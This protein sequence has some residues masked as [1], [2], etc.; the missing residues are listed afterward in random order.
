MPK[1]RS[2]RNRQMGTYL[3]SVDEIRPHL[4]VPAAAARSTTHGNPQIGAQVRDAGQMQRQEPA[5]EH[6]PAQRGRDTP[7]SAGSRTTPR[8][9]TR[10]WERISGKSASPNRSNPRI[11]THLNG[12]GKIR[13]Q[14][15]A[16]V[17]PA[18]STT[19]GNPQIG[20]QV[21]DAGQMQRQ[22]PADEHVPAQRGRDTPASAGSRTTPRHPAPGNPQMGT[23]LGQADTTQPQQPA[24]TRTSQR[25]RRNSRP[26]A[27]SCTAKK[28]GTS[29]YLAIFER[30][31]PGTSHLRPDGN[32]RP[33]TPPQS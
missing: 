5:D 1:G 14:P 6:V 17:P 24:D 9:A 10:G 8:P 32:P 2:H 15:P 22:E 21:R 3:R 25:H 26:S 27:G 31:R 28:T 19:H 33:T 20:A 7:A 29:R 16:S 23:H 13:I 18:R 11:R 12:T 4:P 30:Q